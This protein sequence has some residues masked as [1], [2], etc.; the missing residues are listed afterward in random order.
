M[1][2]ASK[3]TVRKILII[4]AV[5][6]MA[7]LI[8]LTVSGFWWDDAAI[9]N[10]SAEERKEMHSQIGSVIGGIVTDI[11][12]LMPGWSY[13]ILMFLEYFIGNVLVY[14]ILKKIDFFTDIEAFWISLLYAVIPINDARILIACHWYSFMFLSFWVAFYLAILSRGG[15]SR[16]RKIVLRCMSLVCLYISFDT[17]SL[18]VYSGLIILY[19][20]YLELK[21]YYKDGCTG[22]SLLKKLPMTILHNIDNILVVLLWAFVKMTWFRP[23]G[24]YSERNTVTVPALFKSILYAP[25]GIYVTACVAVKSYFKFINVW[26]ILVIVIICAVFAALVWKKKI[27]KT[28]MSGR[29]RSFWM[30]LLGALVFEAG[31]YAY[32]VVRKSDH[33]TMSGING[34]DSIL[35]GLGT[36]IM[37]YFGFEL[38]FGKFYIIREILCI[39]CIMCGVLYFNSIYSEYQKDWYH[40]EAFGQEITTNEYILANDSFYVIDK[41]NYRTNATRTYSLASYA[42]G[43]TGQ[44]SRCFSMELAYIFDENYADKKIVGMKDYVQDGVLDGIIVLDMED[45]SYFESLKIRFY[46]AFDNEKYQACIREKSK[47][48]LIPISKEES[49]KLRKEFLENGKVEIAP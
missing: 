9:I 37:M 35:L 34:R 14:L 2:Y 46:E 41:T 11:C 47:V 10:E 48:R 22:V 12:L 43:V 16:K 24:G 44:E 13:R 49:D 25:R 36:A 15:G 32:M 7:H 4:A 1:R 6:V 33:V 18:I 30:I 21:K 23:Y 28:V 19:L 26:T 45:I 3:D 17:E 40:Q 29:L 20:Y 42:K 27:P 39:A 38:I 8:M 5:Y 31:I